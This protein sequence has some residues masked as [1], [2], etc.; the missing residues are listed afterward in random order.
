VALLPVLGLVYHNF[1][2]Y[3][4]VADHF[5]YL[6]GMGPLALAGAG[7]FRWA[8][9]AI[10]RRPWFQSTLGAGVLV[11]L[12]MLSWQRAWV[13]ENVETLWTDTLAQNPNCW[14]GYNDLGI[15]LLQKGRVDEAMV[16]CQKALEI[17]PTYAPAY[18]NLGIIFLYQGHLDKAVAEYPKALEIDPHYAEAH[19]NLGN[20]LSQKGR[21]DEAIAQFKEAVRLNPDDKDAQKNLAKAQAMARQAP[22]SK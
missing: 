8:E 10:L 6:A 14:A 21:V 9:L 18:G 16:Q 17:K 11:I 12:G 22:G 7:M 15:A 1:P 19:Y 5:Q 4:P 3:S 13:Y 2:Q 20:V